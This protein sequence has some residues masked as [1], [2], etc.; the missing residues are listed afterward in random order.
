MSRTKRSKQCCGCGISAAC[1]TELFQAALFLCPTCGERYVRFVTLKRDLDPFGYIRFPHL[2]SSTL[3]FGYVR[4]IYDNHFKDCPCVFGVDV[5][6]VV[7]NN[8][9]TCPR[10]SGRERSF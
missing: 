10:C 4:Y 8:T 2:K 5:D 6:A 3:L 1:L 7:E 9:L